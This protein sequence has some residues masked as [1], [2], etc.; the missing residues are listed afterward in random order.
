MDNR[1]VVVFWIACVVATAIIGTNKNRSGVESILW[2]LLGPLG[3][4]IIALLPRGKP[5]APLGMRSVTCQRCNAEQNVPNKDTSYACWQC[6]ATNTVSR[7][8]K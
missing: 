2:G 1:L 3:I 6:Q 8:S 4:L 5:P 7:T